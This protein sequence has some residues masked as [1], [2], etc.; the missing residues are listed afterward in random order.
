[1]KVILLQDIRRMGEKGD[2]IEVKDGYAASY[3]IPRGL[4]KNASSQDAHHLVTQL[5]RKRE[6]VKLKAFEQENLFNK[7][8]RKKITVQASAN[9]AG[10]LF[11]SVSASDIAAKLPGMRADFIDLKH[12]I[13]QIGHHEVPFSIGK[14]KG[15]ITVTVTSK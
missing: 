2:I 3:L 6:K 15:Y 5:E 10:S 8:H 7:Y 4:A 12:G 14:Y 11:R 13:K 1:M 9:P